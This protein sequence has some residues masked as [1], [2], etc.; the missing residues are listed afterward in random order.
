MSGTVAAI[1]SARLRQRRR[2]RDGEPLALDQL[3]QDGRDVRVVVDDQA[4][5][6]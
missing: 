2:R 4:P 6:P 1:A 3:G 5:R